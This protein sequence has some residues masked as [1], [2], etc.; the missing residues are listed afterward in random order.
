MAGAD[1][2]LSAED[3]IGWAEHAARKIGRLYTESA[4]AAV[5]LIFFVKAPL[6]RAS[7]YLTD[8]EDV[9]GVNTEP[10]CYAM[11]NIWHF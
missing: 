3:Q 10:L 6:S 5:H 11:F 4:C 9:R 2:F 8:T 7:R 1:N